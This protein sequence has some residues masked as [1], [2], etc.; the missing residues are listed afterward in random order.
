MNQGA[1]YVLSN[2]DRL[3]QVTAMGPPQQLCCRGGYAME[4]QN[5]RSSK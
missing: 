3:D 1:I 2:L 4:S 5:T